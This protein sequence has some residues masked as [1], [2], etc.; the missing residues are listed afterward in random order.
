MDIL[1]WLYLAKNKFVRTTPSSD[2]DLM[3]F[4]AKVGT[5]KRGDLY[6]NYAMSIEDLSAA[7][8]PAPAY[9]VYTAQLT[10][11]GGHNPQTLTSG[12]VTE[13]VTYNLNYDKPIQPWDFSNVG[14]PVYPDIYN[15]VATSSDVPNNYGNAALNYNTGAPVANVVE[16]TTGLNL[17]YSYG[18]IGQYYIYVG[19]GVSIQDKSVI[20]FVNGG[21]YTT[22]PDL[23]VKANCTYEENMFY[24][25]TFDAGT[26]A[27]SILSD[28]D[29]FYRTS[30][31][32]R[33]YN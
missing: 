13:G 27:D 4:G 16:N 12:A 24:I 28:S 3:V 9:K 17:Y 6:Q 5:T 20:V 31:E 15:F 23:L 1:N 21:N 30:I 8:A 11:D 33:V 26:P 18:T 29:R 22:N 10:Q 19:A 14:G 25:N 7:I 32:I 2:K